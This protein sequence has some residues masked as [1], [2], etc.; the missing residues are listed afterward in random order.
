MI[1]PFNVIWSEP[2]LKRLRKLD[3][4]VRLKIVDGV[5]GYG[6]T[7]IGHVKKLR[8]RGDLRL[9]VGDYRVVFELD[10]ATNTMTI[11]DLDDRKDVYR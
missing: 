11:T 8:G 7:G 9:R 5:E 6:Q 4:Q 1:P 3:P 10:H 2:A